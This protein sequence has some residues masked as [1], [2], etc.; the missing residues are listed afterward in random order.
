MEIGVGPLEGYTVS[1]KKITISMLV[2]WPGDWV[3]V[4]TAGTEAVPIPHVPLLLLN[5]D[6]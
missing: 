3:R 6:D 5:D 4:V 1:G 2:N